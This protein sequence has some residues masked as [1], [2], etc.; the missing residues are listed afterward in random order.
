MNNVFFTVSIFLLCFLFSCKKK[1]KLTT[2]FDLWG[3]KNILSSQKIFTLQYEAL[4]KFLKKKI[5]V[6]MNLSPI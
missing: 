2:C 4:A 5:K 1:K 6:F 3:E